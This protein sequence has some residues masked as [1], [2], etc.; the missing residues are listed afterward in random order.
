MRLTRFIISKQLN[1]IKKY[2]KTNRKRGKKSILY[3]SACDVCRTKNISIRYLDVLSRINIRNIDFIYDDNYKH[4][5]ET[6][7]VT[8]WLTSYK[9]FDE[10]ILYYT[11]LHECLHYLI[12]RDQ[13]HCVSEKL[14]HT[15]MR[16]IDPRLI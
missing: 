4:W 16:N 12:F 1:T 2:L 13:K 8:I 9:V 3:T 14:E 5:A 15:I 11:L 6:D 10:D 7:G